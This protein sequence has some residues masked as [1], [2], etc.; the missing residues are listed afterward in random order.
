MREQRRLA[1]STAVFGAATAVS[2]VA[3][4]IR[5]IVAASFFGA[6]PAL[7]AFLIA[8]NVPNLVRSLVAD[9]AISAA[10]VPVFMQLREEGREPEAWRVA[11]IVLWLAAVILG[12]ISSLFI[13]LAP[14]IMPIFV[15]GNENIDPNLVV[16]LS[17][18]MF[19]I[20]AILGMTGVVTGILNSYE[21]F[22]VPAMAP[23]AWNAVIILALV[24]SPHNAHAYAIGVLVATVVQ[25]VIPLPL[26]RGHGQSLVF[27]LAWRNP[28]VIRVLKLMVPVTIGLGLI[29]FNLTL[30]LSIATLVPGGHA[31]AYLNYAFR[32]FMLPQG[33]FSVAVSAVLFPR[34]SGLAARG[35]IDGF[36]RTFAAGARTILFLLLPAAAVSIVLAEPITRLLFQHSSF[37]ATDTHHV[38]QT[39]V[40]FSLGLIGN[41]LALLLTRAFF[42]LQLPRVPTQV[43]FGNLFL[44]AILDLALY[45]PLGAAGIALS[46]AVVTTVNAAIL[47]VLLR[48]RIGF[49][50]LTEVAGEGARIVVATI[51]CTAASFGVWWPLDQILGRSLPAQVVSVGLG[52]TAGGA[53]Y[54][55]AG[56]ILQL[57]DME[58]LLSLAN[59]MRGRTA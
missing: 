53:A 33:L 20:V 42:A 43:A 51:Y 14:W 41:G 15:P 26:L 19:P 4:V 50:H 7:G 59:R 24:V 18:W 34:I 39:L 58:V 57:S 12:A 11:S 16:S 28:H 56:R 40:A 29:N 22:G 54:L 9:S 17:R 36:A 32:M 30:D 6:S 55:A 37:T 38:A 1:A 31:P 45:K 25:F 5:E 8:F 23:I 27:S 35:D 48:R 3:G 21:I 49:L 46:T 10:F 52:L 2:R 47:L 13:L 44:N